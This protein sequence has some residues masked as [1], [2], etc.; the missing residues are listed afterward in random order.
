M[1]QIGIIL[2]EVSYYTGIFKHDKGN[3]GQAQGAMGRNSSRM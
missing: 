1:R 2:M 3:Q